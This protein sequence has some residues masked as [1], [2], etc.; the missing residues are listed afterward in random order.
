MTDGRSDGSLAVTRSAVDVLSAAVRRV[1]G[2]IEEIYSPLAPGGTERAEGY[3]RTLH[4]KLTEVL[5]GADPD[6]IQRWISSG[7]LFEPLMEALVQELLRTPD[8]EPETAAA[9]LRVLRACADVRG[10]QRPAP[11]RLI[12]ES[13]DLRSYMK[14]PGAF[15]L[16]VEVAHDFR[17]PLTSI[18]F[19]AETLRNGQ[20]GP[21]TDLQRSQL[22][23]IYSA[24]FGLAAVASDVM[25]LARKE[26]DLIGSEPEPF[27]VAEVFRNVERMVRPLVEEK[28][29]E[30]RIVVPERWQALGHPH[31]LGRVL[32]NLTTNALKFTDEGSVELGVRP[33]PHGRLEYYVQDTGRGISPEQQRTLFQP[34]KRRP[35]HT[36]KGEGHYFSGSGIGL[37]IARR[38]LR[39]MGSDLVL[40][41]SSERG[42]RF[43]F[44]LAPPP[45]SR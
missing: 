40:D 38:L 3:L 21:V 30:L 6:R 5:E 9:I 16:L 24:A 18:L 7:P 19:L 43:S 39:A 34:F 26:R 2:R 17:S 8:P 41:S 45:G 13:E 25:D 27:A 37:S 11:A 28:H 35:G 20:S 4:V 31:A 15:D 42:T 36:P 22:G 14:G 33:L 10:A 29:L 1:V 32:L 44:V 23:L 12:E